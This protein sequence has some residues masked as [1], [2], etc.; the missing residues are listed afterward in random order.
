M[1]KNKVIVAGNIGADARIHPNDNGRWSVRISV[2]TRESKS[3]EDVTIWHNVCY[4]T[5]SERELEYLRTQLVRGA[6]VYVEG[7][8]SVYKRHHPEFPVELTVTGIDANELQLVSPTSARSTNA[9]EDTYQHSVEDFEAEP[10][11]AAPV[12]EPRPIQRTEARTTAFAEPAPA[13]PHRPTPR[14]AATVMP[15]RGAPM[16][17]F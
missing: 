10:V 14:Q 15:S 13:K 9:E 1:N 6:K 5:S 8:L 7:K 17:N 16:L 11:Q 4:W 12:A 2:A 3:D